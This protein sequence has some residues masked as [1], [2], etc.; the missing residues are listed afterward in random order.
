MK[1]L[2]EY[3]VKNIV[4]NPKDI[5]IDVSKQTSPDQREY[6]VYTIAT[7]PDDI[8]LV[9][10]KNGQTIT[11]IRTIAKIKAIKENNY[12]DVRIQSWA[13]EGAAGAVSLEIPVSSFTKGLNF[14][15]ST[16][17]ISGS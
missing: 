2:I 7:N 4:N 13:S 12:V 9:I 15:I 11:S 8:A 1:K 14:P 6:D 3:I 16:L 17:K 10:G 5:K